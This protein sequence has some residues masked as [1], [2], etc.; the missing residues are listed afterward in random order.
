MM[1]TP[2]TLALLCVAPL[3]ALLATACTRV[4][5]TAPLTAPAEVNA[6]GFAPTCQS[7]LGAYYLP[8]AL[9][10][11]KAAASANVT[12]LPSGGLEADTKF[13]ADRE[14]TL[15]LDYL[16]LPTSQDVVTVQRE[17]N[18]LLSSVYSNVEDRTP[19]I[20]NSLVAIGTNIA[21]ERG[22][23]GLFDTAQPNE[24]LDVEFDPFV[25]GELMVANDAL[26]RFGFCV[27]VEGHTFPAHGRSA[28]DLLAAGQRWCTA[29]YAGPHR[30]TRD[31]FA[32]L[33]VPIE[34]MKTGILYRP[35]VPHKI[36]I[37]RKADP[38]GSGKWMLYQ[39]KRVDV[40]N[41]S[42]VLSIGVE[43][44]MFTTRKTTLTFNKGVLTDVTIDKG[45]E[46]VGFVS[47]PLAVAKAMVDVPGQIVKLRI[48][49]T[50][51]QIALLDAQSK[52]IQS[53]ASYKNVVGVNPA[54]GVRSTALPE[55]RNAQIIGACMDAGGQF[56][57]CK[58]VARS[59]QP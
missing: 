49:D 33:P 54:I 20:V 58:N 43:R 10:R 38:G 11:I 53:I 50:N 37:M 1:R 2:N 32:T 5:E 3:A 59:T 6:L 22:R 13:V 12:S 8:R 4:I 56:E 35:N 55:V 41:V 40:P 36:V 46:L 29:P 9:I 19:Q 14:Q 47:I 18:G 25:W 26:R 31:E 51:N 48:T 15:C 21:L 45:S 17:P 34:V 27:Y 57:M 30:P 52:L 7:A 42:P 16:A 24:T 23:T 28:A 39:T 44:A